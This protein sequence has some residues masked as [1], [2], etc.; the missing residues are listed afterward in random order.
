MAFISTDHVTVYCDYIDVIAFRVDGTVKL[1]YVT[2]L[3]TYVIVVGE[4]NCACDLDVDCES[5]YS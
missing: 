2:F 3:R 1:T 4:L 5:V